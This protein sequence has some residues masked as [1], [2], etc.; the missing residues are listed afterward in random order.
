MSSDMRG[1]VAGRFDPGIQAT[2]IL[3]S[4]PSRRAA[5]RPR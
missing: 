4:S 1:F 5:A 3:S 2:N